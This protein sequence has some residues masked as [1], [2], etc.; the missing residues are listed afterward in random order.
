[1]TVAAHAVLHV[2]E[3][4]SG[5]RLGLHAVPGPRLEPDVVQ[6][7]EEPE[8]GT[9]VRALPT[10]GPGAD[11]RVNTSLQARLDPPVPSARQVHD[12]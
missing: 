6:R 7:L 1:M 4:R 12:L 8:A 11:L 9:E 2:H 10:R 3:S 5:P